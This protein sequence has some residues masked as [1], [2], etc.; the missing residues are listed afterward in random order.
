VFRL[1]EAVL[2][3]RRMRKRFT[4]T[5]IAGLAA[6]LL[7]CS[8][9]GAAMIGIYRNGMESTAQ[10][11]QLIKLSGRSCTRGGSAGAMRVVLGKL[12]DSCSYRTPVIGR[13]LEIGATE[14]LLSG[15]PPALQHA[16]YLGLELRAGGGAK[17]QL[18]VF[19]LQ[20]K[21]QLV[22]VTPEG[23]K[24]LAIDKD[25]QSVQG[26]NMANQLRLRAVN[27]TSGPERGQAQL[28][29]YVG[30][31]LAVEATDAA[32]SELEGGASTVV[33]G[34]TKSANGLIGSVD[35]VI[36]RVPSPY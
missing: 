4:A 23:I 21:V 15:T 7:A 9:A 2:H 19:P 34:A 14:R 18:L 11:S 35:D 10:R 31:T 30:S 33:I 25:E 1:P 27:I 36:V 16:A 13:D 22:K 12:T 3:A 28:A 32:T 6:A 5:L 8:L 24:Y 20:R 17:Y 29:G 26:I